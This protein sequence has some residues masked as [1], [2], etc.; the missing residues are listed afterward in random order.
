MASFSLN[1]NHLAQKYSTHSFKEE[2]ET[3]KKELWILF[4]W[5]LKNVNFFKSCKNL[6]LNAET[7]LSAFGAADSSGL[8]LFYL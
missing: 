3:R 4:F 2:I 7:M 6:K 8:M 1:L 5:K